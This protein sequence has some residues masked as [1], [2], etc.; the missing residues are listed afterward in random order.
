MVESSDSGAGSNIESSD[1]NFAFN[2][3][4]FS[5][6]ILTI[7]VMAEPLTEKSGDEY[8]KRSGNGNMKG[9]QEIDQ[10]NKGLG[11][12]FNSRF[13]IVALGGCLLHYLCR[14]EVANDDDEVADDD[15]PTWSKD[16]STVLRV[17]MLYINSAILALKSPFF[18]KVLFSV[19]VVLVSD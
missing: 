1:F 3:V 18:H 4:N 13:S 7:E 2:N 8:C 12:F 16:S 15:V 19:H 11:L 17:K 9:A 6:R 14:G 10:E 5:D